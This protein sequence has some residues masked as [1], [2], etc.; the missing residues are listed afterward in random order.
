MAE[1]LGAVFLP[2]VYLPAALLA[3][4]LPVAIPS[5][6]MIALS[7]LILPVPFL[8]VKAAAACIIDGGCSRAGGIGGA[9]GVVWCMVGSILELV[10]GLVGG[11]VAFAVVFA[12]GNVLGATLSAFAVW[13]DLSSS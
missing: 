9:P 11:I 1:Y 6:A 4:C 13:A 10:L 2:A 3:C 8:L 7:P 5:L 12:D